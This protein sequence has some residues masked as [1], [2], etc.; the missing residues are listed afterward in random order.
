MPRMIG[1]QAALDII[2]QGKSVNG[3]KAVKLGLA[4]RA[5]HPSIL[6]EQTLRYAEEILKSGAKKRRKQFHAKGAVPSILESFVG[7]KIVFSQAR[8]SVLKLTHGHYPAQLKAIEVI[9]KTYG[10]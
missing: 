6:S 2:L 9:E 10:I 7:R 1:L 4:D 8:K 3:K 5:V